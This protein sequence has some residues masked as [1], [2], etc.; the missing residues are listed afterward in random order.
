MEKIFYLI[1]FLL[2]PYISITQIIYGEWV[3]ISSVN[4]NPLIHTNPNSLD[5]RRFQK[6]K[7]TMDSIHVFESPIN[8]PE[9]YKYQR[10]NNKIFYAYTGKEIKMSGDTLY[11]YDLFSSEDI[12]FQP[13]K[14]G[15]L[16]I[17]PLRYQDRSGVLEIVMDTF[18]LVDKRTTYVPVL[19][20]WLFSNPTLI[21]ASDRFNQPLPWFNGPEYGAFYTHLQNSLFFKFP[22]K[23]TIGEAF[24]EF[25]FLV[26]KDGKVSEIEFIE[27]CNPKLKKEFSRILKKRNNI[28][29]NPRNADVKLVFPIVVKSN[30]IYSKSVAEEIRVPDYL[31]LGNEL[32]LNYHYNGAIEQYTKVLELQEYNIDALFL[33][34]TCFFALK[35]IDKACMDWKAI[36]D[37]GENDSYEFLIEHCKGYME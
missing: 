25:S 5:V 24:I 12:N 15:Y 34:G 33:R 20:Y 10:D 32:L 22:R 27:A 4:I 9:S 11:M 31:K 23:D 28:W 29:R 7:F 6:V 3:K 2:F 26:D 17:K 35:M 30:L 16:R 14:T 1:V 18:E 37:M 19:G 21:L 13:Q 8:K 36:Y